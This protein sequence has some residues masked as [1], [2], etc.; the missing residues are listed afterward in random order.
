VRSDPGK[1][2]DIEGAD[3]IMYLRKLFITGNRQYTMGRRSMLYGIIT[4]SWFVNVWLFIGLT[5]VLTFSFA[6]MHDL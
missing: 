1:L 4:L 2:K 6:Y 3:A 5:I